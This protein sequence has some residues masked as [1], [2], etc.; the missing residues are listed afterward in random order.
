MARDTAIKYN[1]ADSGTETS[2]KA[3]QSVSVTTDDSDDSISVTSTPYDSEDPDAEY[4]VEDILAQDDNMDG[5]TK[6]LVRWAN[7]PLEKCTWEPEENMGPELLTD[8]WEEKRKRPDYEPFDLDLYFGALA[9]RNNR[10]RRRNMKRIRRGLPETYPFLERD[11]ATLRESAADQ[12]DAGIAGT[13]TAEAALSSVAD[14]P[15]T[16]ETEIVNGVYLQLTELT[17]DYDDD[18]VVLNDISTPAALKSTKKKKKKTKETV[19]TKDKADTS[20]KLHSKH[21]N[22]VEAGPSR[23]TNRVTT[24]LAASVILEGKSK[25]N[26]KRKSIDGETKASTPDTAKVTTGL[27]EAVHRISNPRPSGR[28]LKES[29]VPTNKG[30]ISSSKV[31]ET[32]ETAPPNPKSFSARRSA[33]TPQAAGNA[34]ISGKKIRTRANL[35]TAMSDP[36]KPQ[37]LFT[38]R[39]TLRQAEI[40]ERD[41]VDGIIK[42]SLLSGLFPI[43]QGPPIATT[44]SAKV[45][46]RE[47]NV[48]D[49]PPPFSPGLDPI[50]IV[51]PGKGASRSILTTN[52]PQGAVP[53]PKKSVHFSDPSGDGNSPS[54]NRTRLTSPPAVAFVTTDHNDDDDD[55]SVAV[56]AGLGKVA[57]P[58]PDRPVKLLS[59]SQKV[60]VEAV[61]S[62]MAE[63]QS[64]ELL[65]DE[66]FGNNVLR[67]DY[68]CL[69]D[70]L[71]QQLGGIRERNMFS[72]DVNA[73]SQT[74]PS[75]E[76][77]DNIGQ[78]LMV[79]NSGLFLL[80]PM[81]AILLYP[82]RCQYWN[83][84]KFGFPIP[85]AGQTAA[86]LRYVVFKTYFDGSCFLRPPNVAAC[87]VNI[88]PNVGERE[89]LMKVFSGLD[90]GLYSRLFP[91]RKESE[92]IRKNIF[93]A[94]PPSL[95]P[96]MRQLALWVRARDPNCAIFDSSIAG[97]W[98]AFRDKII[99]DSDDGA[100]VVHELVLDAIRRFP[101]LYSLVSAENRACKFW[102]LSQSVLSP[103]VFSSGGQY[104]LDEPDAN[105]RGE[106]L[107]NFGKFNWTQL[108]PHGLAIF[109]TPSF[110]VSEPRRT[111]DLFRWVSN[112]HRAG[113]IL[114]TLVTAWDICAFLRSV[115]EEKD[116]ER[117][118][119]LGDRA[120]KGGS[121]RREVSASTGDV[122]K[123]VDCHLRYETCL[124]ADEICET[125]ET[126]FFLPIAFAD[127]AIDWNDEQSLVNWFG[128]WP[129][130]RLDQYRLFQVVGTDMALKYNH[131]G[132]AIR[133]ITL[134]NFDPETVADP[135]VAKQRINEKV[136]SV[137]RPSDTGNSPHSILS[138]DQPQ[139][140]LQALRS[141]RFPN[142]SPGAFTDHLMNSNIDGSFWKLYGFAVWWKNSDE[143]FRSGSLHARLHTIRDWFSF[144]W[145]FINSKVRTYIG[146]FYLT[147]D[148]SD[149]LHMG[150]RDNSSLP[151]HPF[152]VI[153]RPQLPHLQPF[154]KTELIFWDPRAKD[155]FQGRDML[156]ETRDLT[157]GQRA[158]VDYVREFGP[159]KNKE[160]PLSRIYIGGEPCRRKEYKKLISSPMNELDATMEYLDH[161]A[162]DIKNVV[163]SAHKYLEAKGY[164][165]VLMVDDPREEGFVESENVKDMTDAKGKRDNT[166][167]VFH[168]PRGE[169]M[170]HI[171]SS[172]CR[173]RFY[174]ATRQARMKNPRATKME[175]EYRPTTEWYREQVDEGRGYDH[176]RVDSWEG[177]FKTFKVGTTE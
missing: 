174:D 20:P 177:F 76:S 55:G 131:S 50:S 3:E 48:T 61:F 140:S 71:L 176:I 13:A 155:K 63:P 94:F 129:L 74:T 123:E 6:Y 31:T 46:T 95:S 168:A 175:F 12:V 105:G 128:W 98:M 115:A 60:P 38:K 44:S 173:N 136:E 51:E 49:E 119:R 109:I 16:T 39:R 30:T 93:L 10:H 82:T 114:V 118:E 7:Y 70:T 148:S 21:K 73:S 24:S 17:N 69:A 89:H 66:V 103:P 112:A 28:T 110:I 68:S 154:K 57:I 11:E 29:R 106:K 34:F 127:N 87:G 121:N 64:S 145:P 165:E 122:D 97:A 170:R 99:L 83:E 14:A 160:L 77:L 91:R 159:Q 108:F 80:R 163:P 33:T 147:D 78:R 79:M 18:L 132:L 153:Y 126:E 172:K 125:P 86:P 72:G 104:D 43:S 19:L 138:E 144:T 2:T 101:D 133:T 164:R 62:V 100:V 56:D 130:S 158:V 166:N 134:P 27:S 75:S 58:M 84:E 88:S 42:P 117:N 53:K 162:R 5:G 157:A 90:P 32:L 40:L 142:D 135:D 111:Y 137:A 102:A 59:G 67:F 152:L 9:K 35:A 146:F 81:F 156:H 8:M 120:K 22:A 124:L 96:N 161:M 26:D 141:R 143:A 107:M 65:L 85:E 151:R 139:L 150:H 54:P 23:P 47:G 41:K 171:G 45:V 52:R 149:K 1:L 92:K 25:R 36:S 169:R 15:S 4:T 113:D 116:R 37:Q 167:I